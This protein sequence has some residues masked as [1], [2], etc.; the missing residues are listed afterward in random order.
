LAFGVNRNTTLMVECMELIRFLCSEKAQRRFVELPGYVSVR[1]DIEMDEACCRKMRVER[2][3]LEKTLACSS[4]V[5]STGIVRTAFEL[6][7]D[8]L[9]DLLDRGEMTAREVFDRLQFLVSRLD[10]KQL[11]DFGFYV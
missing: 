6:S 3:V 10:D 9:G 1:R 7:V 4:L 11:A 5:G 8:R 2:Q